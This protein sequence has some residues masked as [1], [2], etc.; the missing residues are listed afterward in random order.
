MEAG[1]NASLELQ[2]RETMGIRTKHLGAGLKAMAAMEIGAKQYDS[3]KVPFFW[4]SK[5]K[6]KQARKNGPPQFKIPVAAVASQISIKLKLTLQQIC[7]NE[8]AKTGPSRG[9]HF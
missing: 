7:H 4:S 1:L 9:D 8:G 2:C 6:K 5:R 3:K